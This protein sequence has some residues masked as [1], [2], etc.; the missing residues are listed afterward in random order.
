MRIHM[1][2]FM[3]PALHMLGLFASVSQGDAPVN[4][5]FF[6]NAPLYAKQ[7]VSVLVTCAHSAVGTTTIYWFMYGIAR[8]FGTT[9]DIPFEDRADVDASQHCEHAYASDAKV[10]R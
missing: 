8:T 7:L 4:G 9:M 5:A 2:W 1:R 6:F 10:S 3:L